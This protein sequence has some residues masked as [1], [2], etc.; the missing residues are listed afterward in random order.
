MFCNSEHPLFKAIY[1]LPD[2]EFICGSTGQTVSVETIASCTLGGLLALLLFVGILL[3]KY[4]TEVKVFMYTHFNW[5]P[6]DRT[7]DSGPNKIYDAFLSFSGDDFDWVVNTLQERLEN[8]D[9][10][11]KLCFHHRDF[12]IGEPIVENIFKSV[13]QSKRMLVVLSSSYAKSDWCLME[14]R[15]AHRK[16]LEDRMKYLIVI[17]FDD[18]DTTELDEEF[19][20]YLRTN[21]YL[22]VS[23]KRFWQK[24]FYAMPLPSAR[25]SVDDRSL[26]SVAASNNIDKSAEISQQEEIEM[27]QNTGGTA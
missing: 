19:K 17:L 18:V 4:H 12:P 14:F 23:D 24:L 8:H 6:Y 10:P 22:S 21:T 20:L 7:D 16:V 5:R 3:Y 15:E 27:T 26:E 9:P 1:S 11:Y 13:D 2:D 25:E